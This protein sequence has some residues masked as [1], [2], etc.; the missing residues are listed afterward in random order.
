[1]GSGDMIQRRVDVMT[2]VSHGS[3][4]RGREKKFYKKI[5]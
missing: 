5:L 3:A 4:E 2:W 1:M